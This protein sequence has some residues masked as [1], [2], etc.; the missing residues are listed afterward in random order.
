MMFSHPFLQFSAL[1]LSLYAFH[2]GYK[3]FAATKLGRKSVFAWK[4][5]VL[6]GTLAMVIWMPG[7]GLGLLLAWWQWNIVFITGAHYQIA[8]LMIPFIVFGYVSGYIMDKRK[9]KRSVLP[10]V[11]GANNLL[12]VLMALAQLGT[13]AKVLRDF[14]LS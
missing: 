8:L 4:R 2:L 13:G 12:L 10:L 3:R 5:H 7:L 1:L 11:H 6:L 9:A 14:V